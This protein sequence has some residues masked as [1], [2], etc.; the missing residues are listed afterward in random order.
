MLEAIVLALGVSMDAAAVAAAR[1]V[2]GHRRE[3][4]VLPLMF[5]GFQAGMAALG[6]LLGAI[7][8]PYIAAWDHWIAF[9]LLAGIGIKMIVE[10]RR[11][12]PPKEGGIGLYFLLSL[13]TSIDAGAAGL[14]LPLVPVSPVVSLSLIG[15]V[16]AACSALGFVIGRQLARIEIL[17]GI[18]LIGLGV[19]ILVGHL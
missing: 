4:V 17:G 13:A 16:T 11:R 12:E 18:I 5:G 8:G 14:T 10:S 3:R 6:W 15:G 9:G 7:G 1:G 2:L 19:K